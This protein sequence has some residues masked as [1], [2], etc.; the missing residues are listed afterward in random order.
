LGQYLP[1]ELLGGL[2]TAIAAR[3]LHLV[4]TEVANVDAGGESY[5][6]HIMRKL[7]VDGVFVNRHG[8]APPPFL[9]RIKRLH[10]PAVFLNARQEFDCIYPDDLGGG[11][12]ATEFLLRLGH[13]RI[14]YVETE[15]RPHPHYSERDRRT[16][17]ERAM[18]SAGRKARVHSLPIDWRAQETMQ[19]D[20]RIEAA[21]ELLARKDRPTAVLAYELAE[22]M[23]VVHAAHLLGLRIPPDLSL[24]V[25]HHRLDDRCFLPMHT[26]SNVM[27]E[28]G[29]AAV[30]MLLEKIKDPE[31]DL[32]AKGVPEALL[33][34]ASCAFP[35]SPGTRSR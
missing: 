1:A 19:R 18:A 17:Y 9:D 33:E 30:E 35:P 23:A 8:D 10:I 22:A 7:S 21:R 31:R 14:A 2:T 32:P 4:L 29:E 3:D 12:L 16:G 26:V 24:V 15:P 6:P 27:K 34:G 13:E 5:V 20:Q 11:T 28:V 25:F